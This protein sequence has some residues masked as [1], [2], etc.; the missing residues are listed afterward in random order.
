[1]KPKSGQHRKLSSTTL[2]YSQLVQASSGRHAFLEGSNVILHASVELVALATLGA[3][4]S[5][6]ESVAALDKDV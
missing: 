4:H 1:M 5:V 3:L 6:V 2:Y